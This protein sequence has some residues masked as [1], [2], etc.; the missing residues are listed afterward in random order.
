M[1][2]ANDDFPTA[3]ATSSAPSRKGGL[4]AA[5]VVEKSAP[6]ARMKRD[7]LWWLAAVLA[8]AVLVAAGQW[9][10]GAWS[11]GYGAYPDEP[12]HFVGGLMV[13]DFLLSGTHYPLTFAKNYYLFQPYFAIGYWPPLFYLMEGGWMLVAG[14]SR[15][16]MMILSGGLTAMLALLLFGAARRWM[17]AGMALA[18]TGLFLAIPSVR[19]S[20]SVVM[21]DICVALFCLATTL[22]AGR[23][24]ETRAWKWVILTGLAASLA[25]LTKY[26]S[27]FVLAPP[28]LLMLIDRRWDLIRSVRTWSIAGIVAV[29]C[30]PW[31][32]LSRK[33]A[34]IGL[35]FHP[36]SPWNRIV[37]CAEVLYT[38][39]GG[40]LSILAVMAAFWVPLNWRRLN[41]AQRLLALQAPCLAFMLIAGPTGIEVRYFLPGYPGLLVVIALALERAA[42]KKNFARPLMTAAVVAL[43]FARWAAYNSGPLPGETLRQVARDVTKAQN[44]RA[45]LVPAGME[46]PAIAE[47]ASVEPERSQVLLIRPSK[48]LARMNWTGSRYQLAVPDVKAMTSLFD[49]Y[50]IDTIILAA[51]PD[52]AEL[53]HDRLLREMLASDSQWQI[54]RR[55]P[56]PGG[57]GWVVYRKQPRPDAGNGALVA[58]MRASLPALQ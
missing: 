5:I 29:L 14:Y 44:S 57:G 13:H 7:A 49:Q 18:I 48:L 24:F 47:L 35:D 4:R 1:A 16:S 17:N 51:S 2:T 3:E 32:F 28:V 11:A 52:R 6:R 22:A 56:Q 37:Q 58:L 53:P 42:S 40:V 31:I 46:G 25:L 54:G 21:T 36:E 8:V 55:Y 27:A 23:Y 38:D 34:F 10:Y 26:L 50:P 12:A 15:T 20:S 30:G 41:S 43:V 45:I 19:W 33:F 9:R 39:L